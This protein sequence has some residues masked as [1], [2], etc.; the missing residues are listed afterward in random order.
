MDTFLFEIALRHLAMKVHLLGEFGLPSPGQKE[1]RDT[2][3]KSHGLLAAQGS[4]WVEPRGAI[5]RQ[6]ARRRN[7]ETQ[8]T[9]P[10]GIRKRV[11]RRTL[12]KNGAI[13]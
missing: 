10:A 13:A 3:Q 11:E 4:R 1:P 5:R 8:E 6:R 12:I 9:C 2:T 7:H